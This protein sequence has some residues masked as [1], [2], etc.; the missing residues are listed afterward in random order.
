MYLFGANS[1]YDEESRTIK[2]ELQEVGYWRK[3][4][5]IHKWMVDNVQ[6]GQDNC[7]MYELSKEHLKELLK[8]C[9]QVLEN[10][11]AENAMETLPTVD[12]FFFG[13]TDL[14]EEYELEYYLHG[15]KYTAKLISELLRNDEYRYYCYQSSW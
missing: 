8:L 13:G 6:R 11:T 9:N 10:P 12:G 3:Q 4:N 2:I 5:A 1:S 14:T 7:A 15:I